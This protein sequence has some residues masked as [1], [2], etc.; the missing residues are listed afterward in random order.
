M[1][2]IVVMLLAV[3]G[4][5]LN[6]SAYGP[7]RSCNIVGS[8]DGATVVASVI[9]VG[10]GFIVV[11]FGNDSKVAVNVQACITH[12]LAGSR[13]IGTIVPPQ[14]STT[15]KV[16]FRGAKAPDSPEYSPESYHI[17]SLS[18]KRCTE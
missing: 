12:P 7:T 3:L 15:L 2:K 8:E 16:Q 14:S 1:K 11:E 6:L 13:T 5:S 18:G 9:E 4:L 17:S 10:D